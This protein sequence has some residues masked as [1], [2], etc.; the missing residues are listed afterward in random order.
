MSDTIVIVDY[1]IKF[2]GGWRKEW[3]KYLST[4]MNW[5]SYDKRI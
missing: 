5:N 3:N 4:T 2:V 1:L